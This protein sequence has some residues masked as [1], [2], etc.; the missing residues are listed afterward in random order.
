MATNNKLFSSLYRLCDGSRHWLRFGLVAIL[1]GVL[2]VACQ[3]SPQ[4]NL[5]SQSSATKAESC[6]V[7]EHAAG[8]TEICGQPQTV[9]AL[10]TPAL[11]ALLALD[12][13]PAAYSGGS[14]R[15]RRFDNPSKQIPVLGHRVTTQPINLGTRT[16]PSL[17]TLVGV[18]PDLIVAE[19]GQNYEVLSGIAPTILLTRGSSKENWSP[20]LQIIAQAFGKEEQAQ[21]V[22]VE[23]E[24]QLAEAREKL[25]P[26]VAAYPRVLPIIDN[27]QN[28]GI[29]RIDDWLLAELLEEIGFEL[30]LPDGA[31]R[32]T[33]DSSGSFSTE[34][35]VQLDPDIIMVSVW[36]G[37]NLNPEEIAKQDWEEN[38][39]LQTMRAVQSGRICF[40]Y[41]ELLGRNK[42]GPIYSEFVLDL[43]P[44]L[45]LP[46]VE[47]E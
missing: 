13:Q 40:V 19:T 44:E 43:L 3:D 11:E 36:R 20:N 38:P 1:M 7:V 33:S 5:A 4:H 28:Q 14:L 2:V 46:F 15:F 24:Q 12:V 30:V 47:E 16:G 10:T 17:E 26:V 9:A 45:L 42:S 41:A 35:I 21:Q 22:I 32:G 18:N 6:R 25:A 34:I 39:L 37:Y 8:E 27:D 29:F 31:L 23:Y